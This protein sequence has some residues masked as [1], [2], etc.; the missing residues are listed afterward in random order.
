MKCMVVLLL[1]FLQDE[2]IPVQQK[3]QVE[4][5]SVNAILI[6]PKSGQLI[7]MGNGSFVAG[8]HPARNRQERIPLKVSGDL[9]AVAMTSDGRVYIASSDGMVRAFDRGKKEPGVTYP[10]EEIHADGR[11]D[12]M[13]LSEKAKLLLTC[14]ASKYV[15]IYDLEKK[16]ELAPFE[17]SDGRITSV[18]VSSDGKRAACG[19]ADG[20]IVLFD[21]R[22]P[23]SVKSIKPFAQSV[24]SLVVAEEWLYAG[25]ADGEIRAIRGEE[26]KF[27]KL[28][29]GGVA[30]IV[31]S[32]QGVLAA[33]VRGGLVL[34]K[35]ESLEKASDLPSARTDLTCAA[36]D[37]QGRFVAAAYRGGHIQI[38]FIPKILEGDKPD[39]KVPSRTGFD[40]SLYDAPGARIGA[41]LAPASRYGKGDGVIILGN[42]PGFEFKG[43]RK[44]LVITHIEIDGA[45]VEVKDPSDLKFQGSEAKVRA[46]GREGKIKVV[47]ADRVQEIARRMK[48]LAEGRAGTRIDADIGRDG[49]VWRVYPGMN[50]IRAG[51]KIL[52][53]TG[54]IEGPTEFEIRTPGGE[55]K[56]STLTPSPRSPG[57]AFALMA[58]AYRA[59]GEHEE[60]KRWEAQ[61]RDASGA[62][63]EPWDRLAEPHI[64]SYDYAAAREI[65]EAG[66]SRAS[67]RTPLIERLA[68]LDLAEKGVD[69]A[70]KRLEQASSDFALERRRLRMLSR[71]KE[72]RAEAI[73]GLMKLVA[74]GANDAQVD[75][76]RAYLDD[77]RKREAKAAFEKYFFPGGSAFDDQGKLKP[78][79]A[80]FESDE[81]FGWFRRLVEELR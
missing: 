34:L 54:R 68:D 60:A 44:E 64:N 36:M 71:I 10:A 14:G 53:W 12:Q 16:E 45:F 47:D 5:D 50:L 52:H 39:L 24:T 40:A 9:T 29:E 69:A 32:P 28:F 30:K 57:V 78:P 27:V 15:R 79:P 65:L 25:S 17:K 23:D 11:V 81:D 76:A 51:D 56:K 72:R 7:A 35:P 77:G 48:D 42:L 59:R 75:L 13:A 26:T 22:A 43:L 3:V 1:L 67:F 20:R 2:S 37:E 62:D 70:L 55:T 73:E 66:L 38:Y 8:V 31:A 49:F 46:S 19:T 4:C 63:F 41:V 33:G 58:G 6:E 61:A 74:L 80:G 21:P 18:A